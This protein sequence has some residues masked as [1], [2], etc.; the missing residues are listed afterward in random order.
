MNNRRQETFQFFLLHFL[1]CFR[2]LVR[3]SD[4]GSISEVRASLEE[5]IDM[6]HI[7]WSVFLRE[8]INALLC[9]RMF[10]R[11]VIKWKIFVHK[12]LSVTLGR[13]HAV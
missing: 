7:H 1:K 5:A 6:Y 12:I 4:P 13:R 2:R 11:V 8:E 9:L 10:D 3:S